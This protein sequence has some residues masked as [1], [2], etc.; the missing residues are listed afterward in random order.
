MWHIKDVQRPPFQF[1]KVFNCTTVQ[2]GEWITLFKIG[3]SLAIRLVWQSESHNLWTMTGRWHHLHGTNSYETKCSWQHRLPINRRIVCF[4]VM[5]QHVW[6]FVSL[7]AQSQ[8]I[9]YLD[10][11]SL[12][13][14]AAR[15]FRTG[16]LLHIKPWAVQ[17]AARGCAGSHHWIGITGLPSAGHAGE[18]TFCTHRE[19]EVV[20][21]GGLT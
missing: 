8:K 21:M 12:S 6:V 17:N 18:S 10:S 19:E 9:C 1:S 4:I 11:L 20:I 5:L 14:S 15:H 2:D 13:L 7:L 16:V 3:G